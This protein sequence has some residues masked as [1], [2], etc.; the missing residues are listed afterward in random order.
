[1]YFHSLE[2]HKLCLTV[3]K[4]YNSP[5]GSKYRGGKFIINE[6]NTGK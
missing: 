3:E 5:I 6:G 4:N 1:M 2:F